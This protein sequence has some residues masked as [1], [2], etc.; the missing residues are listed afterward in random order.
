MKLKISTIVASVFFATVSAHADVMIS[1][2]PTQNMSCS[3]GVCSPT[4]PSAVLNARD[5]ATML[6]SGDVKVT[7]GSGATNIVVKASVGWAST[8]R[9]TLDAM[10]SVE[11]EKP[12]MVTGT[13]GV[14]VTTNDGG[15]GGDLMFDGKGN[16]TFWDL[17]SNLIVNGNSYTLVGDIATLASDVTANPTGFYALA[18]DY[19][20]SADGTYASAPITTWFEGTFEGLGHA[21]DRLAISGSAD[22]VGLFRQAG[23]GLGGT[24]RDIGLTRANIAGSSSGGGGVLLGMSEGTMIVGCYATGTITLNNGTEVGG[25]IGGSQILPDGVVVRSSANVSVRAESAQYAGGLFGLSG[26]EISQSHASGS[27]VTG[28]NAVGGGLVGGEGGAI[29]QSY[30]TGKVTGGVSST[31]GGL[32]GTLGDIADSYAVGAVKGGDGS[33]VGGLAG[34]VQGTLRTSY[35]TGHVGAKTA[36]ESGG[37]IAQV[38]DGST[39]D[40]NYWDSTTTGKN[41]HEGCDDRRCGGQSKGRSTEQLQSGLPAGF[42]PNIWGEQANIN[43]GL[44]YLLALPPK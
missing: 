17:S 28:A 40:H 3:G 4:A 8:S 9:L 23:G 22:W 36:A 26:S 15:S 7:T 24:L 43:G 33:K 14:T 44:P 13:G 20:A 25:L 30:A 34:Q 16:V 39:L 11:I 2:A 19:N 12:V 31:V 5:L 1:T 32:A 10:Q 41:G 29:A 37:L 6:A 42:D 18:N 38:N 21:I 35:S 27:V